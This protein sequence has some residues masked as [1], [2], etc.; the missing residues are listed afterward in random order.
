V[1]TGPKDVLTGLMRR[2]DKSVRAISVENT[3]GVKA[4]LEE[5]WT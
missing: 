5:K 3:E 4:F 2:I 1:E